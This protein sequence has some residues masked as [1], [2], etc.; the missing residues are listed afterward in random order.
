MPENKGEYKL[1]QVDQK[2]L[3]QKGYLGALQDLRWGS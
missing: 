1:N 2:R 3:N